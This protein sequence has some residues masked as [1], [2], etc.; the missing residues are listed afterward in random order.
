MVLD[1]ILR[2]VIGQLLGGSGCRGG[3]VG[4]GFDE[5]GAVFDQVFVAAVEAGV[6]VTEG[7]EAERG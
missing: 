6:E 5:G 3:G 2:G 4:V 1:W 7:G